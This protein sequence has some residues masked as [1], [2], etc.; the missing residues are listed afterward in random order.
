MQ[1]KKVSTEFLS[2]T[3]DDERGEKYA[4]KILNTGKDAFG[5][6]TIKKICP[7]DTQVLACPADTSNRCSTDAF[8]TWKAEKADVWE[9]QLATLIAD[10]YPI[11]PL[12]NL[13]EGL[14]LIDWIQLDAMTQAPYLYPAPVGFSTQA[15]EE[16]V[17]SIVATRSPGSLTMPDLMRI[18]FTVVGCGDTRCSGEQWIK[19]M[20]SGHN[21]LKNAASLMRNTGGCT[22]NIYNN[23]WVKHAPN[24]Q[25]PEDI[26]TFYSQRET[27][28]IIKAN[29]KVLNS[30]F[31][32]WKN[33]AR[34]IGSVRPSCYDNGN[35]LGPAY[36][37]F[38]LG[39]VHFYSSGLATYPANFY[40]KQAQIGVG[41]NDPVYKALNDLQADAITRGYRRANAG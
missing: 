6:A 10:H 21:V 32:D 28:W 9:E 41:N 1:R 33:V 35:T 26:C 15:E 23:A 4:G 12:V 20:L 31:T 39:V 29:R 8:N 17:A 36:H 11:L 38:A 24:A 7:P 40:E 5:W 14:Q 19:A 37:L 3:S 16:A 25:T 18:A 27:D 34:A 30:K 13:I 22:P 2:N